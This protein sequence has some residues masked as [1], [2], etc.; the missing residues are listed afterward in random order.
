MVDD[1]ESTRQSRFGHL[2]KTPKEARRSG[3]DD[4][5]SDKKSKGKS[6]NLQLRRRW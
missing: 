3:G 6:R 1:G 5:K 4:K 2:K